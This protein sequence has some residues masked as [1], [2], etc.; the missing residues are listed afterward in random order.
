MKTCSRCQQ[1]LSFDSF[2]NN[3]QS[4]DGLAYY[5]RLCRREQYLVRRERALEEA[6]STYANNRE[7]ILMRKREYYL[8]N[9][10]EKQEYNEEYYAKHRER[11]RNQQ[12]EWHANNPNFARES[13]QRRRAIV[14]CA[15]ID[16]PENY[17][18]ILLEAYGPFCMNPDCDQSDPILTHD[19]IVPLSRGGM[20][21]LSNSQI[22]CKRCNCKKGTK[23]IDYRLEDNDN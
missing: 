19:H 9:K 3:K 16:M 17:W 13:S 20:H 23:I 15:T 7:S 5:C 18:Q 2:G 14:A 6:K 22:L 11:I 8:K 12:Q 10:K 1:E 4:P 21:S